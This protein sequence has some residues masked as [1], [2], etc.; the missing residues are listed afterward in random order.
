[1]SRGPATSTNLG[2]CR[3]GIEIIEAGAFCWESLL[4]NFDEIGSTFL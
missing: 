4:V 3:L 1:L 2:E